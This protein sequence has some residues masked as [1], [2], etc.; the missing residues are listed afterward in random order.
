MRPEF[1]AFLDLLRVSAAGVVFLAHVDQVS[2]GGEAPPAL[3]PM[4]HSAVI[5][6]FLL[7]GT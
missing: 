2:S 7:S 1:S 3:G 5:V 6:F 4:A